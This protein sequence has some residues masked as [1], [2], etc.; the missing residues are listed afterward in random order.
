MPIW[1]LKFWK[2]LA[3]AA[4][5]L[6]VWWALD[7]WGD[8]REQEGRTAVQA[9]WDEETRVRAEIASQAKAQ[10]AAT[11]EAARA[12]NE[13]IIRDYEARIAA[14]AADT[15]RLGRLLSDARKAARAG[16][17]AEAAGQ[18][19]APPACPP[20]EDG[21]I[22]AAIAAALIE[23]RANADQLDALLAQIKP[24]L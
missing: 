17:G 15:A 4:L 19:G 1:L 14:G 3:G 18:P 13:E 22:D 7:S 20:G 11:E 5:V 2:P 21:S 23:A 24:Q 10:A 8:S 12:R 16:G 9:K 6:A